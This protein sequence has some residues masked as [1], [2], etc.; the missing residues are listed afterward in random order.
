MPPLM[1]G[2][3]GAVLAREREEA[4]PVEA[5]VVEEPEQRLVI[6]L[7]LARE[8]DDERRTERGVGLLGADAGD[9]LGEALAAPPTLHAAQQPRRRVLQREIEVRDDR[10]QLE[11]RRD[12]RVLHLGR[13]EVEQPHAREAVRAQRIEPAQQ[14]CERTRLADV[15]AVPGEVLGDEHDLGDALFDEAAPRPRSPRVR[16]IAACPGTTGWRRTRRRDRSLR[17]PSRTPT[18]RSARAG[19]ARAGRARRPACGR[20]SRRR[21][22]RPRR[23]TRRPHRLPATRPRARRRSA[24]PCNR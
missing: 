9:D 10:R 16:A 21:R 6:G 11:H 19:A 22:A 7:G 17:P 23:R 18:A 5:D 1:V 13:I 12:E 24:R 20:A 14:R 15:A 2:G 8:P 4:G 3:R